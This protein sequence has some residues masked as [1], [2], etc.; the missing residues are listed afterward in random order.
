MTGTVEFKVISR[1]DPNLSW[2]QWIDIEAHIRYV[3]RPNTHH[4]DIFVKS[5]SLLSSYQDNIRRLHLFRSTQP[6]SEP[7][8]LT[9]QLRN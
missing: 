3:A 2:E 5:Q 7:A 4:L 9:H 1:D 8:L 6:G